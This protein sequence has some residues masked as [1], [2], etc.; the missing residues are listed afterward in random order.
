MPRSAICLESVQVFPFSKYHPTYGFFF[1]CVFDVAAEAV[2]EWFA[3]LALSHFIC[4]PFSMA[5]PNQSA[6]NQSLVHKS[7]KYTIEIFCNFLDAHFFLHTHIHAIYI[8]VDWLH[9]IVFDMALE[10]Q[11]L[12][13]TAEKCL[14]EANLRQIN[15]YPILYWLLNLSHVFFAAIGHLLRHNTV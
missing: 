9:L 12:T 8:P 10:K 15:L 1:F 6:Y 11:R 2:V 4:L 5:F 7:F 13:Q 14:K 3:S